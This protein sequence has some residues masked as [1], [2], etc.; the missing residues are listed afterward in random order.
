MKS[1]TKRP[2]FSLLHDEIPEHVQEFMQLTRLAEMGRMA[3]S[4]AHEINTPLMIAQGFA[5]NLE[6]MLARADHGASPEEMRLQVMEIVKACQRMSRI[7]TK[8]NRM[9]RGQKLRL[10]LVDLAEVVLNAVDFLK[11]QVADLD[12]RLEFEFSQPMPI[13]CDVV[14]VEQIVLN[15]LSNALY[16]LQEV[17]GERRIR[18]SFHEVGGEWQ[19]VRIWNNGPAIPPD[20]QERIM[21]PFLTTKPE[22]QGLG[23]AVSKAIM[24]VHGGDLSCASEPAEGTAFTLSFPRPPQNPWQRDERGRKRSI[25]IFDRQVNYRQALEVKFRLMGFRVEAF[26]DLQAGFARLRESPTVAGVLL[27]VVPGKSESLDSVHRLRQALGP[28]GLI[29]TMSHFPSARDLK[30]EFRAAGA[31]ECFEKPLH[32][33]NFSL[34]LKQL[35]QTASAAP[36]K[37]TG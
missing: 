27:D 12:V 19:Q 25:F 2:K 7:V 15:V 29:Y 16:A 31:N 20:V 22:G 26:A 6:M 5:E 32:A 21:S 3:A 14:Q 35:D 23:L 33:E 10:H 34:I 36:A 18:L 9:S 37:V 13:K 4:V 28:A 11:V 30:S 24:E 1:K 17:E 8:M